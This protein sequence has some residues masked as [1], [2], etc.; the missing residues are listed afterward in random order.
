[1]VKILLCN[2][3]QCVFKFTRLGVPVEFT[4]WYIRQSWWYCRCQLYTEVGMQY[5]QTDTLNIVSGPTC[6]NL[7][8]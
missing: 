5:R 4:F 1:M 2:F 6:M 7:F 3:R 8:W